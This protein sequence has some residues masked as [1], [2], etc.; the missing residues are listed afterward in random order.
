MT[1]LA[2]GC[3]ALALTPVAAQAAP[4]GT[5]TVTGSYA[6]GD[7]LSGVVAGV[8]LDRLVALQSAVAR[9]SGDTDVRTTA[10]PL[11]VKVLDSIALGSPT[12]VN[13]NLGDI[14]DAGA[15]HQ[16]AQAKNTG[17]ALGASGAVGD[18]GA[19]TAKGRGGDLTLNLDRLINAHFANVISQL[20]LQVDAIAAQAKGD[21]QAVSGSYTL[22][23]LKLNFTSPALAQVGSTLDSSLGQVGAAID[24]LGGRDGQLTRSVDGLLVGLNPA[25]SALGSSATVK[26]AVTTDLRSAVQPLLSTRATTPGVTLDLT[27]GAVTV[28]LDRLLGGLN[29]LPAGTEVLS[30]SVVNLI[31]NSITKQLASLVDQITARVNTALH[32]AKVDLDVTVKALDTVGGRAAVPGIPGIPAVPALPAVVC[33]VLDLLKLCTPQAAT[34]GTPAIPAVPGIPAVLGTTLESDASVHVHGTVDQ[35]L[36][37]DSSIAT[38]NASLLGGT[39]KAGLNV[40]SVLGSL[41]TTL[42]DT[43]FDGNGAVSSL[44]NSLDSGILD[45]AVTALTGP[46][47]YSAQ[48]LLSGLLSVKLNVKETTLAGSRGM[49]VPSGSLFT[50]TA[51]RVSVLKDL[52]SGSLATLNLAQASVGPRVAVVTGP[53]TGDPGTPGNPGTPGTGNGP[54]SASS[55]TAGTSSRLAFTGVEIGIVLAVILALLA[56]GAYLVR[57]GYRRRH[58][59]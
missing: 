43:L 58:L 22:E 40:G 49:A 52:G 16:Y 36:S 14:V 10:D 27:T 4:A 7:F 28:D 9:N 20:N 33:S 48:G 56:A 59:G 8:D 39:V 42:T 57:E 19:I 53:P 23:G 37:G 15:L 50:E 1:A 11:S 46:A 55:P 54:G 26:A 32:D 2:F 5:T 18:D 31:L 12:G 17:E 44:T 29:H 34:P 25:L 30:D 47:D 35:L 24:G 41:G 38:A 3:S 51:M 6:E 21:T 45:P 13:L